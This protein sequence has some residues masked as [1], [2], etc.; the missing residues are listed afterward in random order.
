MYFSIIIFSD[1]VCILIK[2]EVNFQNFKDKDEILK[3][4]I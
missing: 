2:S 1:E 3:E 4:E